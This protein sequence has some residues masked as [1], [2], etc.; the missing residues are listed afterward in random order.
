MTYIFRNIKIFILLYFIF[1]NFLLNS[2]AHIKGTYS[3]EEEAQKKSLE[4]GCF[5]THK[6]K[7]KWLPC[8]NEKVLHKY[9]RK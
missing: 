4:L 7:E 1:L 9:L 6:N 2:H 8:E 3:S 5:G